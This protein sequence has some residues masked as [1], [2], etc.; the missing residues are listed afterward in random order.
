MG[1]G[2]CGAGAMGGLSRVAAVAAAIRGGAFAIFVDGRGGVTAGRAG[3]ALLVSDAAATGAAVL[4][5]GSGSGM[6]SRARAAAGK[7]A[8]VSLGLARVGS[9]EGRKTSPATTA[10]AART[11]PARTM[12]ARRGGPSTVARSESLSFMHANLHA[13]RR[14]AQVLD[15]AL[16]ST[17]LREPTHRR[18]P[19][20]PR[21]R[22]APSARRATQSAAAFASCRLACRVRGQKKAPCA[23]PRRSFVSSSRVPSSRSVVPRR[24]RIPSRPTRR[25]R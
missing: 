22:V 19:P 9:V 25:A 15:V 10:V 5:S 1:V 12:P 24:R 2:A 17:E 13:R 18:P 14:S 23:L 11:T 21:P 16:S 4:A 3:A 8:E 20:S 6:G 7:G